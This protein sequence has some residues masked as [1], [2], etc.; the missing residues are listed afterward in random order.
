LIKEEQM[1]LTSVKIKD[2]AIVAQRG[3]Y[4]LFYFEQNH[5]M[6]GKIKFI[7]QNKTYYLRF[8]LRLIPEY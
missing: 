3:L 5:K 7:I 1:K 2:N 6:I 8:H 4:T